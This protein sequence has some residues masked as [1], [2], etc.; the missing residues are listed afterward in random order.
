MIG[1]SLL[2][3]QSIGSMIND[4]INLNM[5]LSGQSIEKNNM[6]VGIWLYKR[7][8]SAPQNMIP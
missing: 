8:I 4:C 5:I 7:Y 1:G 3:N 2:H 6:T